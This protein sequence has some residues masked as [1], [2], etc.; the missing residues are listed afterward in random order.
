VF[1]LEI[2]GTNVT[3]P[4]SAPPTGSANTWTTVSDAGIT[5][6]AGGHVLRLVSDV[7]GSAGV[8]ANFNWLKFTATAINPIPPAAPDNLI[9]S[10]VNPT[11]VS[12]PWHDNASNETGFVIERRIGSGGAWVAIATT[13][14]NATTY[15]DATASPATDYTYRVHAT[16][17]AGDSSNSNEALVTTPAAAQAVFL[18]DLDWESAT[19][20]W[21][22]V[23]RDQSVGGSGL[24]D[25][26]ALRLNGTTYAKGL[27]AHAT[28]DIVY[29]LDGQYATFRSD[30]G[31]D[32]EESGDGS[33]VFQVFADD[34]KIFDSG[35]MTT[36]SATQSINVSVAGVQQLRLHVGNAGDGIDFDHADWAGARLEPLGAPVQDSALIAA[37]SAWKYLDNGSNQGTAWRSNSFNDSTWKSGNAELGYGDGDEQT[38]V[39]FGGDS[40]HKFITTYFR[41][42]FSIAD[43]AAVKALAFRLIR[44]DGAAVYLNGT[45]VFR[46]NL[47][48][49]SISSSTFA[50]EA[51]GGSDESA[52][53]SGSI[54]PS[55]LRSG[56]N[57][58][59]V[60]IHQSDPDSSD[61][62]FNFDLT[63]A[64]A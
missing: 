42:S 50:S 51:L 25:G 56:S 35:I 57:V 40:R 24:N 41:K 64:L 27:G 6:P 10:A 44:D 36:S 3:G 52:W 61:I 17:G 45:E 60:E 29:N 9:A 59:A 47:P 39:S 15:T 33:V 58:I 16:N 19:N 26:G 32:D 20:G 34:V 54:D 21:G 22:P 28:S 43:P 62:S 7:A 63:A 5:L 8:T 14:A 13:A 30:V 38:I 18:S 1:H 12:L 2:D 11:T 48:G 31:I 55:L 46:D 37:N 49:G 53:L 4:V 23:E